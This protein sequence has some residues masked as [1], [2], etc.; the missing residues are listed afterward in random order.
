MEAVFFV[1]DRPV[2]P[3]RLSACGNDGRRYA[4]AIS[5]LFK[6]MV[7]VTSSFSPSCITVPAG[8]GRLIETGMV[9]FGDKNGEA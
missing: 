5:G 6:D 9:G 3:K 1:A 7:Y 4:G 8:R 2:P